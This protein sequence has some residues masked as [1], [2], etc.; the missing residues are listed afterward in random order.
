Q[1]AL[2]SVCADCGTDGRVVLG[3]ESLPES[4]SLA[5]SVVIDG[6][7][8]NLPGLP[9]CRNTLHVAIRSRRTVESLDPQL[10]R[11]VDALRNHW[12]PDC[13]LVLVRAGHVLESNS[14]F[15]RAS[16]RRPDEGC[17]MGRRSDNP[18]HKNSH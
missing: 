3:T 13:L 8:R 4:Q 18:E 11:C 5:L 14:G 10:A 7:V 9:V 15:K 12:L 2:G 16:Q 6:L 17:R 1:T